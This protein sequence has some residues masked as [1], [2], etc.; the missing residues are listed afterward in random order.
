MRDA[1]YE[2]LD[3]IVDDLVQLT[4]TVRKAVAASTA[5]LLNAD[6]PLAEQVIAGDKQIDESTEEIEERALLLLATQ[7]PV[8]TD[9][10]QLVATLRMLTDLQR[11]GDLSVHVAKVAR[12]RMPDVAVPTTLQPTIM[13]MASVADQMIHAASRIVANRDIDAATRL[14]DTDDEMDR[15]RKDLFRALLGGTWEHGIEPAIDLALLGRYY[16]RIGDHAVSMARRVVY[17]VTGELAP[18]V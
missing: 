11:M 10:R 5:A 8:A 14:E 9:L 12:M 18:G 6:G 1:Y 2:Q 7:Q 4:G 16:E 17:L 15:L 13:A 3:T